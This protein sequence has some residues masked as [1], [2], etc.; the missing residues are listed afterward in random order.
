MQIRIDL[1]TSLTVQIDHRGIETPAMLSPSPLPSPNPTPHPTPHQ[2][3]TRKIEG[4][5]NTIISRFPHKYICTE[6]MSETKISQKSCLVTPDRGKTF[7]KANIISDQGAGLTGKVPATY[8]GG[9]EIESQLLGKDVGCLVRTVSSV[10]GTQG[11][12]FP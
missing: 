12:S 4:K 3:D 8:S 2:R 7:N 1:M 9:P 10:L 11:Q 6:D 5:P